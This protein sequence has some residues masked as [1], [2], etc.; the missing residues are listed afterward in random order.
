MGR[1]RL[2][3]RDLFEETTPLWKRRQLITVIISG[4]LLVTGLLLQ[5]RTASIHRPAPSR[6]KHQ[7]TRINS[8]LKG[9]HITAQGQPEGRHP[10]KHTLSKNYPERVT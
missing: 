8:A 6:R 3:L 2:K 7:R 4:T 10:G 9:L 5:F 1:V